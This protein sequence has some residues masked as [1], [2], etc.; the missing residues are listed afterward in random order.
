VKFQPDKAGCPCIAQV[1]LAG[2]SASAAVVAAAS[3][4]AAA[5][6]EDFRLPAMLRCETL[7]GRRLQQSNTNEELQAGRA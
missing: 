6:A 4:S 7:C 3:A 5:V 2:A 1:E